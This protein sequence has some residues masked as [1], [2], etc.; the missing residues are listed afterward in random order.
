MLYTVIGY[1]L[2]VI[3]VFS[4]TPVFIYSEYYEMVP[5]QTNC[6]CF[7]LKKGERYP[8]KL[9]LAQAQIS[10]SKVWHLFHIVHFKVEL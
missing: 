9:L 2:F 4:F 3:H 10:I 6:M 5:I 1:F 7:S 8:Q